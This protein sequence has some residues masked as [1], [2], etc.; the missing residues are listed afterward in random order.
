MGLDVSGSMGMG[1]VAGVPGLT[2]RVATAAMAMVT[3][4][5]EPSHRFVAFSHE[6]VPLN[7]SPRQ[8]LG[9]VTRLTSEMPFGSTDCSLPMQWALKEKLPVD[10]FVV[11]TDSETWFGSIHPAQALREYRER[12]GIPAKMV[13][14]G[15]VSNGFTIADPN[16]AGMLDVVGFDTA[17]P[18][19]MADFAVQ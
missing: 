10:I 15:M 8:R 11:L 5:V 9:D 19:L 14:V 2:P 18:N 12:M 6:L 1:Q 16:D 4:A 17:T 13:V 7:I 3:A